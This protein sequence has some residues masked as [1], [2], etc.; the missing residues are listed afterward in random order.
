MLGVHVHDEPDEERH[1]PAARG[2]AIHAVLEQLVRAAIESGKRPE[3]PWT[4][5]EHARAQAML[6]RHANRMAAEGKAGLAT[7]WAVHVVR[8][9]R[10]LRQLL[11][12]DDAYRAA[13][14]ARP[15]DVEHSFGKDSQSPPLAL[16]LPGGQ[17]ELTGSIDRIDRTAVG[18]LIVFDYKTGASRSYLTFPPAG[19]DADADTDFTERGRRL[20]LPLYA[21]AA[22][23]D[24][25]D[26][27]TPVSAYY[28]F[29]DQGGLRR[30][31]LIDE[32]AEQRFHN[33]LDVIASGVRDGAF[34]ARPGA[35]D[36]YFRSFA[37]CRWCTFDRVC[38]QGRGELW[39][40]ARTHPRA[41]PYATLAEPAPE[42]P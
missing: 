6:T 35:F 25:G 11:V 16:D 36:P 41:G 38:S 15:L 18:G 13:Q 20:Q 2:I 27:L 19:A 3:Q 30:G 22:R 14:T 7:V 10:Q 21:V 37:N 29:I 8:W 40:R 4:A 12:A 33:V 9:R 5:A 1:D 26:G 34:P 42:R 32:A 23:R 24:L 31:G 39:Q 17:V 28:W